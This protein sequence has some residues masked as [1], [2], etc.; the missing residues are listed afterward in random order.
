V[1][2]RARATRNP[3][4]SKEGTLSRFKDSHGYNLVLIA[5]YVPYSLDKGLQ[6][7]L[8]IGPGSLYR[9]ARYREHPSTGIRS[10]PSICIGNWS[11]YL[12]Y[13]GKT[14]PVDF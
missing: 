7:V 3:L 14:F 6:Q 9:A 13:Q 11:R 10:D 8:P 5:L 1:Q 2:A 4:P 12:G